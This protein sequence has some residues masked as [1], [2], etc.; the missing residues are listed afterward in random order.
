[1]ND[2]DRCG[3]ISNNQFKNAFR[4]LKLSITSKEL[5]LLLTFCDDRRDGCVN[6]VEFIKR[7]QLKYDTFLIFSNLLDKQK[8]FYAKETLQGYQN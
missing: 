1:M 6:Y 3:V 2:K 5:D 8:R 4:R 7:F